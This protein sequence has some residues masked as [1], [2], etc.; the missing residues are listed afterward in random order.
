MRLF[1]S[2]ENV[3]NYPEVFS[4]LT[5]ANKKLAFIENAKDDWAD[6]DRKAKVK[7]HQEQL[8]NLGFDFKEINLRDFFN[9][10][11]KLNDEMQNYG[12]VF[13]AG[14]NTFILRRAMVLSGFDTIIKELL[15]QD[16]LVYGGSSAGSVV[17]GPTLHGTEHGDEPDVIP[18]GY[19][20]EVIW[21]GL[22][23]VPFTVV[24]HYGSEWFGQQ[25]RAMEKYLKEN[26]LPQKLLKDGQV[27]VVNDDKEEFLE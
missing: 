4:K 21:D 5:G 12:A 23:L 22:D 8:E 3:G 15:G 13:V 9:Q 11:K 7:E 19:I 14:G 24:P 27:I 18:E 26:N 10:P 6:K 16:K 25:A 2:S 17:A 1:L 20:E